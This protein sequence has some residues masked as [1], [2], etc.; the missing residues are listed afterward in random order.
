MSVSC[1][2]Q[3]I[4]Q[5][6][7]FTEPKN[8]ITNFQRSQSEVAMAF[9]VAGNPCQAAER[10]QRHF[11]R[12]SKLRPHI[13]LSLAQIR[14][15]RTRGRVYRIVGGCGTKALPFSSDQR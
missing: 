4:A 9:A 3:T 14:K 8:M 11:V 13:E 5:V 10:T 7:K 1:Q 15:N 2:I 6:S 12:V